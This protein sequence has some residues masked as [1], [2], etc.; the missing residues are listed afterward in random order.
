[1]LDYEKLQAEDHELGENIKKLDLAVDSHT[2]DNRLK[3]KDL[4]ERR[5]A[6]AKT[7]KALALNM[8]E[9]QN[10]MQGLYQS[11]DA[12]LQLAAHA[13]GWSWKEPV[14]PEPSAAEPEQSH[15]TK[16]GTE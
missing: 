5:N 7:T 3:R 8:Q 1:M 6:I 11:V 13:A 10:A 12:S 9:G 4:Q 15:E 2:K 16:A 14:T